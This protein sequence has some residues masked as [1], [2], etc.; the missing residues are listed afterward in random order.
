VNTVC[1]YALKGVLHVPIIPAGL[2]SIEIAIIHNFIGN[3]L[4]TW[5]DRYGENPPPFW[6]QLLK[7]NLMTGCVDLTIN[8]TILWVLTTFAGINY[9]ISNLAGMIIS[10]FIKFWLNEKYIFNGKSY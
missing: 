2:I 1:L 7:Y 10:P 9:L 4:W 6:K 3:R 5:K 8:V